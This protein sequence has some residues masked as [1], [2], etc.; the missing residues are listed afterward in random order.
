MTV[1]QIS[2]MILLFIAISLCVFTIIYALY[3]K[4]KETPKTQ[5]MKFIIISILAISIVSII[6]A[7]VELFI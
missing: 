1:F 4:V 2:L 5:I 7:I 6:F 3:C